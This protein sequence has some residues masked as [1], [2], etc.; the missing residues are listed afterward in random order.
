[1]PVD[2]LGKATGS[3]FDIMREQ[4]L[5]LALVIMNL[6][7]LGFFYLSMTEIGERQARNTAAVHDLLD[8]CLTGK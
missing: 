3:F 8:K 2:N 4:P 7:I 6:A 5:S 1:V